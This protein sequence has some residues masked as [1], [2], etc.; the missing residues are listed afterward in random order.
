MFKM[1]AGGGNGDS[2]PLSK[3][4]SAVKS[5]YGEADLLGEEGALKVYGVSVNG[6]NFIVALMQSEPGSGKVVELGFLARFVGFPMDITS[7]EGLNRNLQI[8]VAT[9]EGADLF[10]MAGMEVT[11]AYN[12]RQFSSLLDIWRDDLALTVQKVTD[13]QVTMAEKGPKSELDFAREF[14]VNRAAAPEPENKLDE[15]TLS[16]FMGGASLTHELCMRCHGKGK[17]GFV[18]RSCE[19]CDGAG[20]VKNARQ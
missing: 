15:G 11:G 13:G 20:F 17:R 9:L 6:I 5:Q 12:Q 14:A 8:S 3:V 10:L 16:R 18:G 19:D 1:F 7:V 4:V 2:W